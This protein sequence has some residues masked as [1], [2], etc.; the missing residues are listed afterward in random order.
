MAISPCSLKHND[1]NHNNAV[2][3]QSKSILV[4]VKNESSANM[5][6]KCFQTARISLK[7]F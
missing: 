7:Q 3:T 2:V 1:L 5:I 4:E 6:F